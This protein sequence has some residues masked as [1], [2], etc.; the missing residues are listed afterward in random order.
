MEERPEIKTIR[1]KIG[2]RELPPLHVKKPDPPCPH[3][4]AEGQGVT[5]PRSHPSVPGVIDVGWRCGRCGHE[6][7]FEI[8]TG[9]FL[10]EEAESARD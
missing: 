6:Y 2:G 5:L 10:R 1:F 9:E 7:G 3:C 4:Q 8:I